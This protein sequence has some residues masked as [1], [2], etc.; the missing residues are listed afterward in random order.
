MAEKINHYRKFKID[1]ASDQE[2]KKYT[3]Q[4]INFTNR[5]PNINRTR[6]PI[7]KVYEY[8]PDLFFNW[9]QRYKKLSLTLKAAGK[10]VVQGVKFAWDQLAELFSS[11][12]GEVDKLA[13]QE[14]I[15]F[16]SSFANLSEEYNK[17]VLTNPITIY[18]EFFQGKYYRGFEIP[19]YGD[20]YMQADGYSGWSVAD[21][22]AK[23]AFDFINQMQALIKSIVP[24]DLP[25]IPE[26]QTQ[27]K[28]VTFETEFSLYNNS[29]DNLSK[30]FKFIN[31]LMQGAMWIQVDYR[32]FSSNVY[33]VTLPGIQ[34]LIY[35]GM[36]INVTH[37]GN[38]R[39]VSQKMLDK[40]TDGTIVNLDTYTM[41][42]DAW[43]VKLTFT[44]LVPNNYNTFIWG[45]LNNDQ[46]LGGDIKFDDTNNPSVTTD[47]Q[48]LSPGGRTRTV[49]EKDSQRDKQN[50]V[51]DARTRTKEENK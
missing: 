32:H 15:D 33:T 25:I 9:R 38:R 1:S 12:S 14:L 45:L 51:Y 44:S 16:Q 39:M 37:S 27:N 19:Y 34:T 21:A 50:Q 7:L 49:S 29:I 20:M 23:S 26:W 18:R 47:K 3:L 43:K 41:F 8:Q 2:V 35:A 42:P 28:F 6:V 46:T 10:G 30:N 48:P 36:T 13:E 4:D 11:K 17:A 24:M 40:I 31:A 22:S 5:D